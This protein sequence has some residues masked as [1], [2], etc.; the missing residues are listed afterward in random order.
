ML[1]FVIDIC[2]QNTYNSTIKQ[3][4]YCIN[5]RIGEIMLNKKQQILADAVGNIAAGLPVSQAA[6]LHGVSRQYV[7]MLAFRHGVKIN[8]KGM[9]TVPQQLLKTTIFGGTKNDY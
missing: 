5:Y 8:G 6:R 2:T 4:T 3:L 1:P 9:V 7:S